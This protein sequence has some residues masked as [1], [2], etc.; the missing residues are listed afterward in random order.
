LS[1]LRGA[2]DASCNKISVEV[3]MINSIPISTG[4]DARFVLNKYQIS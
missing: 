3:D 2:A 4:A 1:V